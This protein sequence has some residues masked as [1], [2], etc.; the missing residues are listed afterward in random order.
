[1][2]NYVNAVRSL[3]H[4]RATFTMQFSHYA[5]VPEAQHTKIVAQCP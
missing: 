2:F 5:V 1:M 4:G 3:S